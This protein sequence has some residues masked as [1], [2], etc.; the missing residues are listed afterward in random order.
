MGTPSLPWLSETKLAPEA[1]AKLPYG[2]SPIPQD[3]AAMKADVDKMTAELVSDSTEELDANKLL[4]LFSRLTYYGRL[5]QLTSD[6]GYGEAYR[7]IWK[8]YASFLNRFPQTAQG[9]LIS[10]RNMWTNGYATVGSYTVMEASP[11]FSVMDRRQITS[12][13]YMTYEANTRDGYLVNAPETG[14]RYNH[15]VFPALS[16]I[17]G[18]SYFQKYHALPEASGWYRL[19]ERIFKGNTSNVNLDEG[20]DYLMHVPGITLEYAMATGDRRFLAKGLRPSADLNA[21]MIDNLGTMSGGGDVYPFGRSSAYSWNHSQVMN[22]ASWFF[23]EPLYQFLLERTRTGPFDKQ[24]MS[25]LDFPFHRFMTDKASVTE[26]TGTYP[27]VQSYPVEQGVYDELKDDL[28]KPLDVPI[29]ET[30]HKLAFREGFELNDSYLMV[31]GFSDGKHGHMDG[32]TIIKYSAEGRIFIDDRD[33]IEKAPK[34]HTGMLVVKDGVQEAKPPLTRLQWAADAGGIGISRSETPNYNGADWTRSIISPGGRFFLIYDDV[35]LK[36][37]GS[38]MLENT[39]QTLGSLT[40]QGDRFDVEQKGAAMSIQSLDESDLRQ[41]ERYGHF[42]KYWK[43]IYPYPYADEE[44][45]LREV[46]EEQAYEAGD[47]SRFINVLSSTTADE[48]A[49]KARRLNEQ[50]VRIE[51]ADGRDWFAHWGALN[52][53]GF[54]TDGKFLLAGD[55]EI[56]LAEVSNARIGTE[57]LRFDQPVMLKL[58]VSDGSWEAYRLTKGMTQ[59]DEN[60]NPIQNGTIRSGILADNGSWLEG[61]RQELQRQDNPTA[62]KKPV[63]NPANPNSAWQKELSFGETVTSSAVGD[64]DGD[65][66]DDL[67]LGGINGKVQAIS[68]GGQPLWTFQSKGRVNE[69]TVQDV[70]GEPVIFVATENWFVHVVD[71]TGTESWMVEIPNT[72]ER[73]EQKGNLI[74]VTTIRVAHINGQDQAPWIM[75]GTQFRYIYGFDLQGKQVYEDI[76]YFYGIE[77]LEF[78]D[79]DEDGKDEGVIGLEYYYYSFLNDGVLTRYGGSR[80]PGPGYKVL[81]PLES[82]SGSTQP[83]V[84]IGTKQNRVHLFQFKGS[85][86]ELWNRNVGGEVNDIRAGDFDQDGITEVLVASD[87]FQVYLLNDD[88]SVRWRTALGDRVMKAAA[89][90]TGEGLRYMAVTDNGRVYTLNTQ[91]E[92]VSQVQYQGLVQGLHDGTGTDRTWI[93]L[94]NGDVYRPKLNQ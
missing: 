40:I 82:W 68:A 7:Y 42:I 93:V 60:G 91:G 71:R 44:H 31:D 14:A 19:G 10:K 84:A 85:P 94:E 63:P 21:M 23:N 5:Y 74:G 49:V 41:Y 24:N 11:L 46:K 62:W 38:Y 48:P 81:E 65:G 88:G 4:S 1:A 6:P 30:F 2:T 52:A 34:N 92:I 76:A 29:E 72:P 20:S 78:L 26:L 13:L 32:N 59:Y 50:T 87:G 43:T 79:L 73:R 58:K 89:V 83:A 17:F 36:E 35:L 51:E 56:L 39:W 47:T 28:G 77:D 57:T 15:D 54:Q 8:G 22:A 80:Q 64:L 53:A 70:Q 18:A 16:I 67:V 55:D 12:A 69:V 25:D 37:N 66:Q 86:T 27:M 75:V 3:V 90:Q 61:L 33:Y 9:Q 45:V